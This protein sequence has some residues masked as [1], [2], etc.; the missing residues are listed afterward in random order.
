MTIS[1]HGFI[2][3]GQGTTGQGW[4]S[5]AVIQALFKHHSNSVL[6]FLLICKWGN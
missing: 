3:G 5:K 1:A 6:L 4:G 2:S